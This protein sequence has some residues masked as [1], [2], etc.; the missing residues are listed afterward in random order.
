M[1][2]D[3]Y[4]DVIPIL[5]KRGEGCAFGV[6]DMFVVGPKHEINITR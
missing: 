2:L 3:A 6:E 4:I 1:N 5:V